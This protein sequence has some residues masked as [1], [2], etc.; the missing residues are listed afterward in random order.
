[1]GAEKLEA[2]WPEWKV[3]CEIG[4]GS[5]GIVYKAIR[6]EH[7]VT[8]YSA[9]KALTIPRSKSE[10]KSL[11]ADGMDEAAAIKY[12]KEMVADTVNE[13]KVLETMKGTSNIVSVEDYKVIE[14]EDKIGWDIYIRMELLET[15]IDYTSDKTLDEKEVARLG[16]DI[17]SALELCAQRNIIHRDIK[18]ENIFLSP[19]GD[20]KIGDFGV[21]R[22]IETS[23]GG[24]SISGTHNYMAPEVQSKHYDATA[25]IYSL[26]LVLYKLLNNNRLP[27]LDPN[28]K[29]I[30]PVDY[31]AALDRRFSGETLPDPINA[32][33]GM[34]KF[35]KIACAYDPKKR[36]KT[37]SAFKKALEATSG[38][39]S[40]PVATIVQ[41]DATDTVKP[42]T[43]PVSVVVVKPPLK[44]T[45]IINPDKPA[46]PQKEQ[47][48]PKEKKEKKPK[49][50]PEEIKKIKTK[51][52]VITVLVC[53]LAIGGFIGFNWLSEK[54]D[55]AHDVLS[56]YD[57]GN[58]DA[59]TSIYKTKMNS[60]SNGIL[61]AGLKERLDKLYDDYLKGNVDYENATKQIE[62]IQIMT[63]PGI[64]D[65]LTEVKTNIEKYNVSDVALANAD[66]LYAEG[67][68][69]EA[70]EQYK[71]VSEDHADYEKAQEG[72][73]AATK[74]YKKAAI[75]GA[76]K[77][78]TAEDYKGAIEAID[79]A[80]KVL[81]ED[82][83]L[84]DK[85]SQYETKF[86]EKA[87][88]DGDALIM[89]RKYDDAIKLL[90]NASKV[91][92]GNTTLSDRVTAVK[93]A[94]PAALSSVTVIDS[95]RYEAFKE[96][97]EDSFGNIYPDSYQFMPRQTRSY[98]SNS[99]I[100]VAF[101]KNDTRETSNDIAYAIF[102]L[103]K[104]YKTFSAE[105]VTPAGL[106]SGAQLLIEVYV[107]DNPMPAA[108][109]QGITVRSGSQP[110]SINVEGVTQL[111]V[112]VWAISDGYSGEY[113]LSLVNTQLAK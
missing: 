54:L 51:A 112:D 106:A 84:T 110:I 99:I 56:E 42:I 20:F 32:S 14:H 45:N 72:L 12:F 49:K 75:E 13:I 19:F 78:A 88:A 79:A 86:I 57:A 18:P 65:K 92:P 67:K 77:L 102:N 52:I 26:G 108:L 74:A 62:T 1:M 96:V 3:E 59:A 44:S 8:S 82:Q 15:F 55:P 21:A 5:F 33:P 2:I 58:Y 31:Q 7:G 73:E 107:D 111:R 35:L 47:K 60:T 95:K 87:I 25:D 63:S 89:E 100:D 69:A 29:M 81:E 109:I 113:P 40:K 4:R 16:L 10:L 38:L 34:A 103:N 22:E 64:S 28:A 83:E 46:K 70:I 24:M 11:M 104:N 50:T 6:E 66:A 53:V 71:L 105:V 36:F 30:N 91:I 41:S 93:D 17:A 98:G 37:A 76:D 9:I 68:Y 80:L 90:E 85:K 23:S 48:P 61:E 94:K 27:F 101:Y 97:F 39:T 43:G